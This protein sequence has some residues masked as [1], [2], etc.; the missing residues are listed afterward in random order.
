[1]SLPGIATRR[2]ITFLMVYLM[3]AGAGV[4][5]LIQL[6]LDYLPK[7]DL[8]VVDIITALPGAGPEEVETLVSEQIE[9]AVSGIEGVST[10]ESESRANLSL[11]TVKLN[12]G[13]DMDSVLEDIKE[14]VDQIQPTLP[15]NATDPYVVALESS[16]KPLLVASFSSTA[17]SGPE[18]RRLIEDEIQP[19]LSRIDGVANADISGGEVRQI[20]VLVDPVL[21]WERGIPISQVYGALAAVG[22]DQPGGQIEDDGLEIPVSMRTGFHD[23]EQI[24]S[25]VVG[26]CGGVPVRLGDVAQVVDGFEDRTNSITLDGEETILLVFRK[27]ADANAVSTCRAINSEIERISGSY[28]DQLSVSVVYNQEDFV[29]SSTT[30]LVT[31]AIQAMLL[32]AAVLLLFL[33]SPVN[34]GIVSIS[35]P[36]SFIT[37]FAFMYI[38]GVNLN[39]IS[40]AGLSI[41]IGMILDNSVVVLEN[42]HRRRKGGEGRLEGAERGAS[43]VAGPVVASAL[44]TVVVFVPMLFVKGLTGQIFRDLSI[45]IVSALFISLFVCLSLIPMLAGMSEKLVKTHMKGSPLAAIQ[46]WIGRLEGAY[47]KALT[48]C[49]AHRARAIL[50]VVV[51]FIFSLALMRQ[52][53]TS[54][55]PDFKEGTLTITASVPPGSNLHVTDSIATALEDSVIAVIAPGDLVHSRLEVGRSSGVAAVFGS[56]A[57]SGLELTLYFAD[58]SALGTSIDQY[59]DRIRLVLDG[60]PGLEYTMNDAIS[61]GNQYPIQVALYGTDLDELRDR[62]EMLRRA[63][64]EIPGTIDHVSSLE[65]RV[66]QV[67]FTPDPA[68]LSQRGRSP[69]AVAAEVTIGALG[70]DASSYYGAGSDIDVHVSYPDRSTSTIEQVS[71][72]PVFGAPL[73]SWGT[74]VSNQVPQMIW[75][76]DRSR[77]VLVSC[78]IDGRALGDVG[79]DLEAMM[80]TLDLGGCRWE[81]LGDIPDQKES[82]SSMFLAILVAVILVFMVMAA[83]FESLLEPFLLIFSIPMGLIGVIFIHILTGATLGMTSLIGVLMLAGIVVNNGIVLVDFANQIRR[84]EGLAPSAAVVEAGKRRMRPIL[85]TASTTILSLLP[86]AIS[87]GSNSGLW[88][89]MALTVIGGMIVATPLTLLVLPAMYAMMVGWHGRRKGEGNA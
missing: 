47:T 1:M 59:K 43:Q 19:V 36:L 81:L 16:M 57:S 18:L 52:I 23:L 31:S 6:G 53:P 58:E 77:A 10:V 83:Q 25:L 29:L 8:G 76:R 54:L 4:F 71:G 50:P 64:Q 14:A 87:G 7:V 27:S 49:V 37:T 38:F 69:A 74:F 26:A 51:I 66:E 68:V 72:L 15:D 45:T 89:P 39:I 28:A 12:L 22:A 5:G 35:M 84:D 65:E 60:V 82:F 17:M 33:G 40:L 20:N 79:N 42:I 78:K 67:E 61:I 80:D 21:I 13:A 55:F 9:N 30:S 70:L 32:A 62:G 46:N 63:M 3:M 48:W 41:S 75:H 24:S 85:M 56:D 11:V 88:S 34:A 73:S 86:L 2:R 44:T